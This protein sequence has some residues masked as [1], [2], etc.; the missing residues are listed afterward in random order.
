M[1]VTSGAAIVFLLMAS[2][3]ALSQVDQR[4]QILVPIIRGATGC[5][6][7]EAMNDPDAV[8]A[9]RE[10]RFAQFL[11]GGPV[12]RCSEP[13]QFMIDEHDR[14]YGPGTGQTFFH[15]GY[16][17]DLQRAVMRRIG[18]DLQRK[19]ADE[20]R[21]DA[22]R[23]AA[24][25]R[26][27]AARQAAAARAEADRQAAIASAEAERQRL[28][29]ERRAEQLRRDEAARQ[30]ADD[31]RRA[32]ELVRDKLFVCVRNQL[33][34]LQKS[35]E[36]ATVLASAAM[37]IC[38]TEVSATIDAAFDVAKAKAKSIIS[39]SEEDALRDQIRSSLRDAVIAFAVQAKARAAQ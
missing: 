35:G 38:G 4:R 12:R 14:L 26:A 9:Y 28:E 16:A 30:A 31:A 19:V 2:T 21:A 6:A 5:I 33:A 7:R 18:G 39:E 8:S 13:I 29:S 20:D 17:D 36:P 23:K 32:M 10:G 37:T 1:R 15:G 24:A 27:E 34:D 3:G 25:D 11:L 22:E